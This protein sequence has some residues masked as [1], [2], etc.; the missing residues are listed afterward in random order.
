MTWMTYRRHG[1]LGSTRVR[2]T[3]GRRRVLLALLSGADNLDGW[4]LSQAAQVWSAVLYPF[5]DHLEAAGWATRATPTERGKKQF[6]WSLT[7]E[8]H[9]RAVSALGLRYP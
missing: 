6:F 2:L 5:L 8:G 4:R 1:A 9:V 7:P 3:R